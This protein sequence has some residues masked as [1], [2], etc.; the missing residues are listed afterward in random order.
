M[1]ILFAILAAVLTFGARAQNLTVKFNELPTTNR[2]AD[3][4]LIPVWTGPGTNGLKG[5]NRANWNSNVTLRGS[6]VVTGSLTVVGSINF[7]NANS[8]SVTN[9]VSI[10]EAN[11]GM[12]SSLATNLNF[13]NGTNTTVVASGS[14][15]VTIQI[16]S[17]GGDPVGSN[18][19]YNQL[20]PYVNPSISS[21][22]ITTD[23]GSASLE[24]GQT[25]SSSTMAWTLA[26]TSITTQHLSQAIGSI[27]AV[28][29]GW[30]NVSTYTTDRTYTLTVGDGTN[31]AQANASVTFY[32]KRY[33]GVSVNSSLNDAQILLLSS[34][35][36][37]SFVQSRSLSPS[38][39]YIYF[40]FPAAF[41]APSFTVNGLPNTAW[42]L[43]T[44]AFINAHSYSASYNI[45]RS[46]NLLTG[47][48]TVALQ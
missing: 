24:H 28:L 34:E 8:T 9:A 47:T 40:A 38:A 12:I 25:V 2:L 19:F 3:T 39:Q 29:R 16:S 23:Q 26:G 41:G 42:T 30:T 1:R 6:T 22:T 45:Y 4:N 10:I 5:V 17:A 7:S 21:F 36:A 43:V 48:Y 11:G 14:G 46:D 44:R 15:L 13:V 32:D 37:T 18:Y 35:L 27:G 31:Q 20:H 33:W